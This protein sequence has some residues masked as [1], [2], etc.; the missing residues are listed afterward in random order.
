MRCGY[1]TMWTCQLRPA[2]LFSGRTQRMGKSTLLHLA[3]GS[4]SPMRARYW[5]KV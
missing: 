5:S 2:N 4:T 1:S 3:G